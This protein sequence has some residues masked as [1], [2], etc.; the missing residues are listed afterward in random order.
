MDYSII[1][2]ENR[3]HIF[4]E[5]KK[6]KVFVGQLIY[7]NDNDQYEL[8]YDKKYVNSKNAIPVGHGLEIFQ[9]RH[10]S[11]RGKLFPSFLDRIPEKE[12]PAYTDYCES[13]GISPDE[14]NPII[15][16]GTIGRRG[17]SSFIFEPVYCSN[18][19]VSDIIKFRE[20]LQISQHDFATAFDICKVT[21]QRIE[22]GKSEDHNTLK[23]IHILLA[24]PAVAL[25]Q[26]K[27]TGC[28]IHHHALAK[29]IKYFRGKQ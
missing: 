15:L 29:L 3:L 16:L 6:R 2:D 9:L 26:L 14:K 19:N 11:E 17:P 1:R 13:Q 21:L 12:N 28:H 24:F 10:Y 20:K 22:T 25:W 7:H 27:Q 18:F 5:T 23:N 4:Y 8:I